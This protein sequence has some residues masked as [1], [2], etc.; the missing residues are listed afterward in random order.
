MM[1]E[2]FPTLHVQGPC[3][4]IR[5]NRPEHHNRIDPQDIPVLQ[6]HFDAAQAD[7]G[8]RLVVLTGSGASTFSSGYTIDAI[9][10]RLDDSFQ[11]LLGSVERCTKPTVCALNGSVYGGGVDLA[12]CCDV[13]IGVHGS[14]LFVPAARF[15]LHYHPDGVRRFVQRVGPVA[16]KQVFMMGQTLDDQEMLRLGFLSRLVA[17]QALQAAVDE[18]L[19]A[20]LQCEPSVVSS[21]KRNIDAFAHG[22]M[23]ETP[24]VERYRQT[25]G[26]P[27]MVRRLADR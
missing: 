19:Q 14:R 21:L 16:A 2:H 7:E 9:L 1:A 17:P 20:L 12:L 26:S 10:T 6:A 25:L 5:L 8:V 27:E 4:T 3:A 15:G 22:Q 23:D 18:Q 24:W 11:N 13:R